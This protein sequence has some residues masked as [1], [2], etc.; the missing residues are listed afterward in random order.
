[1]LRHFISRA[2]QGLVQNC[3]LA[4]RL[5][6]GMAASSGGL[7]RTFS[8]S[9]AAGGVI[10]AALA[11]R[12]GGSWVEA[13]CATDVLQLAHELAAAAPS[14]PQGDGAGACEPAP[15]R[16]RFACD[17]APP[18]RRLP[19]GLLSPFSNAVCFFAQALR[20]GGG[21]GAGEG[22]GAGGSAAARA[23]QRPPPVV[24]VDVS[25]PAWAQPWEW[26]TVAVAFAWSLEAPGPMRSLRL[27][28]PLTA[29]AA[30][31][32]QHADALRQ[33]RALRGTMCSA[34]RGA[35]R[36]A[37]ARG[38]R[39]AGARRDGLQK[40]VSHSDASTCPP[41]L[42]APWPAPPAHRRRCTRGSRASA[43]RCS[44]ARTAASARA[45]A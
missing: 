13:R 3:S 16:L 12:R 29:G 19:S 40:V 17:D 9:D 28:V 36:A 27:R 25:L 45:A 14:P 18:G 1:M 20:L 24:A 33:A 34:V 21:L 6:S 26:A 31:E 39:R 8:S 43:W 11:S 35:A 4:A 10:E 42:C 44:W 32:P 23:S 22:A 38:G 5:A 15:L 2:R 41:R 7:E 30:L 37:A